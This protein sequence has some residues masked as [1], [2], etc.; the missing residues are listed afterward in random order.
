MK[1][2]TK[3]FASYRCRFAIKLCTIAEIHD[4]KSYSYILVLVKINDVFTHMK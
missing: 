1:H 4:C 2:I 3:K